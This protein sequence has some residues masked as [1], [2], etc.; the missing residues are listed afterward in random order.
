YQ[1]TF[2]PSVRRLGDLLAATGAKPR[3]ALGL[4][5]SNVHARLA[6][7]DRD[8][9]ERWARGPGLLHVTPDPDARRA[10]AVDD[11]LARLVA[12][13]DHGFGPEHLAEHRTWW[14]R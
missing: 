8:R 2:G 6:G 4:I 13:G 7:T 1:G 3:G 5:R 14:S 12:H 9:W 10:V 11:Y